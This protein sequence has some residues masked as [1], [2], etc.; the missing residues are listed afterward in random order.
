MD[1]TSEQYI[2]NKLTKNLTALVIQ[3]SHE[4]ENNFKDYFHELFINVQYL[5]KYNEIQEYLKNKKP[6]YIFLDLQTSNIEPFKLIEEIQSRFP[7]QIILVTSSS[8]DPDTLIKCI[9]YNIASFLPKPLTLTIIKDKIIHCLEYLVM[10]DPSLIYNTNLSSLYETP[11]EAV[12]YL[13]ENKNCEIE[14]INHYK[15]VP[16]IRQ[17]SILDI[18]NEIVYVK[19]KDIQKYILE[20]SHHSIMS[21]R[22]LSYDIYAYLKDVDN[23]KDI[24]SFHQLSF[25]KSYVHHRQYIRI[26]PD[27][28]FYITVIIDKKKYKCDVINLS[29]KYALVSLPQMFSNL[30]INSEIQLIISFKL[31]HLHE[32]NT[33]ESHTIQ[34]QAIINRILNENNEI[35]ALFYF[36]LEGK[37]YKSLKEYIYARSLM[38]IKEFKRNNIPIT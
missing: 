32:I 34:T 37:E 16:L 28:F 5:E 31:N 19:I 35:R 8:K 26:V 10:N 1:T 22:Y 12:K 6:D 21:S 20:Y 2:L 25:I 33:F 36:E 3:S 29:I 23:E 4:I 17:A 38:L 27:N 18:E 30:N 14:L 13:I 24:A 9:D 11:Y 7:K 15:G